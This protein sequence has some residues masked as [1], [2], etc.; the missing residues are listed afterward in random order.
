VFLANSLVE[1]YISSNFTI[2]VDS[3]ARNQ[4]NTFFQYSNVVFEKHIF[5]LL[6]LK[7]WID[8]KT[9]R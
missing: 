3:N 4:G 2:F 9:C 1:V 6:V 7:H 5:E 8:E